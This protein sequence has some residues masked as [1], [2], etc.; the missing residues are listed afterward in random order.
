MEKVE[1]VL[2]QQIAGPVATPAP[3]PA[4]APQLAQQIVGL[5]VTTLPGVV[6][7]AAPVPAQ[8]HRASTQ[9]II[10]SSIGAACCA[11]AYFHLLKTLL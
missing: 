5:P 8:P 6:P 1:I 2:F 9:T 10:G 11:G 7:V 3:A 4:P